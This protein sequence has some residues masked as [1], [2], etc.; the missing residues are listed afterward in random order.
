MSYE[1][2]PELQYEEKIVFGLTMLQLGWALFKQPF[3][4]ANAE[5]TIYYA[6]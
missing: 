2:P 5:K 1:I 3:D 4:C 6:E